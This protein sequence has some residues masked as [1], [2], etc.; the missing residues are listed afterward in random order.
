MRSA[1]VL[2][3]NQQARSSR[4][5]RREERATY[6]WFLIPSLV[7]LGTL[8]IIPLCTTIYL[9]L[10]NLNLT[11]PFLSGFAGLANFQ[12]M[13]A[14][15]V[16]WNSIVVAVIFILVPVGAQMLLGLALALLLYNKQPIVRISRSLFIAPMVIP[17]VIAGLIWKILFIPNLGGLNFFLGL[18]GIAGPNWLETPFWAIVSICMVAIWENTPFVMLLVLAALESM[19]EEPFEAARVDG[20]S[21]TQ[22]FQFITFPQLVPVLLVALLFRIIDA[23]GIFPVIFILTGGGPGRATE[24][25]NY[26]AYTTGFTYLDIGYASAL[27][28]ALF[29]LIA[30]ISVA[31]L[32]FKL[33]AVEVE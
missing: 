16:F 29:V 24:P 10:Q 21:S 25:L 4:R 28:L 1:T 13:A 26:Y 33:R 12:R 7:V 31:F 2:S 5:L 20:A 17:P 18:I 11:Q 22:T 15:P 9:S 27:A 8:S 23:L 14:D 6:F 32:R 30:G 3:A 19:P